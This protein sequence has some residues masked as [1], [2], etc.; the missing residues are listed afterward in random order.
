MRT[1]QI[2]ARAD[3]IRSTKQQENYGSLREQAYERIK[4]CILTHAFQ[5]GE[6]LNEAQVTEIVGIGRTPVHQAF[7]RLRLEGLV[8]VLPRKGIVVRSV[9]LSEVVQL[10]PVRIAN[11]RLCARLA[12]TLA[13]AA[14]IDRLTGILEQAEV[15]TEERA[16]EKLVMLDRDFHAVLARASQNT[17]LEDVLSKLHER[18]LRFWFLSLT[19]QEQRKAVQREHADI[20]EAIRARDPDAAEEAVRRHIESFH[21]SVTRMI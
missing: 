11:E 14:D 1:S 4:H 9:S 2:R 7:D 18:G 17:I 15:A 21:S 6:Y 12:A 13:S 10:I 16:T 19:A 3:R 8:D 5:P 20:V